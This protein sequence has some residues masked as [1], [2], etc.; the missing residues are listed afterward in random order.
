MLTDADADGSHIRGLVLNF[1]HF[2]WPELAA[3]GFVRVIQTPVVRATRGATVRD[4]VSLHSVREWI[5]SGGASHFHLKYYKGL[6]TWTHADAKHLLRAARPVRFVAGAP[7][8]DADAAMELGFAKGKED[9]RKE[10]I[11]ANMAAPP[12]PDYECAEMTIPKFVHTDLVNFSIYSVERSLPSVMDGQKVSQR[13]VLW[14][15]IKKGHLSK[16]R[17]R[18]SGGWGA[19]DRSLARSSDACARARAQTRESKV[20]A[21][22]GEVTSFTAYLH[23][24]ASLNAT[25]IN[26]AQ[27]YVGAANFNLLHPNGNFGSRLDN[28][29]D[30]ASARYV[31]TY[32]VA[33]L[34]ALLRPEDD[35]LLPLKQE[36]GEAVEPVA[37]WPVLPV[38]LLNGSLAIGT[39][40]STNIPMYDPREVMRRVRGVLESTGESFEPLQPSFRGFRGAVTPAGQGKWNVTGVAVGG[41]A[42]WTVTELPP[43]WSFNKY[44]EW[45]TGE[46]SPAELL[47][48]R[49]TEA[50]AHFRVRFGEPPADAAAAAE[51]LQLTT[52]VAATNMYA[53]A[54]DGSLRKY[55]S[56]E[57]ILGEWVPWR[58]ERYE[59]RHAHLVAAAEAALVVKTNTLRFVEAVVA[60]ELCVQDHAEAALCAL[61]D[62]QGFARVKDGFDYLLAMQTRSFTRDR[63]ERLRAEVAAA[64]KELADLRATTATRMWL[65]DLDEL[66]EKAP[67]VF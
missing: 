46:K 8:A 59:E 39:G 54:P 22:S 61:L 24:E 40:F 11:V 53:F 13:K 56:A 50:D 9:A 28:G 16:V 64:Q 36:E 62:A 10:W 52:K 17:M 45:L 37:F 33:A 26:M 48:N 57:D 4:F 14:T 63:A 15:V 30:A 42:E 2:K 67:G 25:I 7:P 20:A 49:C 29:K 44:A 6:G 32:G 35:D 19:G 5:A 60:R 38:L 47:E 23:G 34:R 21:L 12:T 18:G 58:L 43:T 51:A 27:D 66:K 55:A 41:G 1:L 3:S 65:K 31:N